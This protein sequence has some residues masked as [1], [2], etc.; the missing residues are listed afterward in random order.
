MLPPLMKPTYYHQAVKHQ[1]WRKALTEEIEAMERT[2]TWTIVSLPKDHH[3][4]GNKWV[5]KIKCKPDGT[6]DRYKARVVAKGIVSSSINTVKDTLKAHFKL[7]DLGQAK[8][9]LGLELSRS[10]Q[11]L[12]LS[13]RKYCF[14]I[15][16][17]TGFLD[18]KPV[19]APM[20]PNLK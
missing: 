17:D 9:V 11:G 19:P 2:K 5:Y 14:Q 18:S 15:L 20:D 3:I 7:K 6:I 1:T 4:I 8:Y 10:Q 12:M 16:K 13:Q